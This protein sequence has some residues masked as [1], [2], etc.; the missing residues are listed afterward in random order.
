MMTAALTTIATA[1]P[2]AAPAI[3]A[4]DA[5]P[6]AVRVV[7]YSA[8]W[9][10]ACQQAKAWMTANGISFEER[11]IDATTDYVEQL[12]LLSRR[13]VI[14]TFDIDGNVMVGFNPR[15]LELMLQR[16]AVRR[17]QVGAR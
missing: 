2:P 17:L 4:A 10:S 12:R 16:A 9:C 3:A 5:G 13:M 8:S 6:Q 11:D 15:R 7:I 14:P 1:G